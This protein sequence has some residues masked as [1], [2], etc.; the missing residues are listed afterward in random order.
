MQLVW[1]CRTDAVK[2]FFPP[3]DFDPSPAPAMLSCTTLDTTPVGRSRLLSPA[4]SEGRQKQAD[5]GASVAA[6]PKTSSAPERGEIGGGPKKY[7]GASG[8]GGDNAS[9]KQSLGG[10]EGEVAAAAAAGGERRGRRGRQPDSGGG[11][12]RHS[13]NDKGSTTGMSLL[14]PYAIDLK[15]EVRRTARPE[16]FPCIRK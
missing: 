4:H 16:S 12:E 10:I 9:R 15:E 3:V 2:F 6:A 8:Q 1:E 7:Q 5:D 13:K 11:G 14:R